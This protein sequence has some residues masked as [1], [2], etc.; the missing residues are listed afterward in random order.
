MIKTKIKY[1]KMDIK[2]CQQLLLQLMFQDITSLQI[3][4]TV[5]TPADSAATCNM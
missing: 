1:A 3:K 4:Y 5:H 2:Q